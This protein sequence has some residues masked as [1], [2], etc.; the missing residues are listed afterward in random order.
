MPRSI[1][2]VEAGSDSLTLVFMMLGIGVLIPVMIA[3]NAYQYTVFRGKVTNSHY[4]RLPSEGPPRGMGRHCYRGKRNGSFGSTAV[5][6]V[7]WGISSSGWLADLDVGR[8]CGPIHSGEPKLVNDS[9][10]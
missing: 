6:P 1:T 5:Y 4:S 3:Y 10:H 8:I 9:V 7:S 2:A